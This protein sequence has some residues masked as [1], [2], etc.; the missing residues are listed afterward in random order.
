LENL[1]PI[2]SLDIES[3]QQ[4]DFDIFIN[5]P[6]NNKFVK[7]RRKGSVVEGAKLEQLA[8][9]HVENFY[10][11]RDDYENFVA[12]VARSLQR[13][14]QGGDW[15]VQVDKAKRTAQSLLRSTF[16]SEDPATVQALVSNLNDIT[17]QIIENVL[18]ASKTYQKK[19][20]SKLAAMAGKGSDFQKHPVNIASLSVL[21]TYGIGYTSA[22]IVSDV[23]TAAILHDVGLSKLNSNI[24][25]HS[26][27]PLSLTIDERKE[28]YTHPQKSLDLAQERGV[29]L[30]EMA[31]K[32]ILQHHESYSGGGYPKSIRGY[33]FHELAQVL[34]FADQLESVISNESFLKG[35]PRVKIYNFFEEMDRRRGIDPVLMGRLRSVIL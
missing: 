16:A 27:D 33:Q 17:G 30:T 23:A 19:M 14:V 35:N 1:I 26:H 25:A 11:Y 15:E 6:L 18:S 24:V 31:K 4:I 2:Q 28:L 12:Y 34:A 3:D 5:L 9:D 32:L 13:L 8:K 21:L 20:F 22:S 10:I 7:Y 29:P